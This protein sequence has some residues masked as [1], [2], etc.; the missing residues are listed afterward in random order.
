M[1][2]RQNWDVDVHKFSP[3]RIYNADTFDKHSDPLCRPFDIGKGRKELRHVPKVLIA[4]RWLSKFK[5]PF[6]DH[7]S[8]S[9]GT[10]IG[11]SIVGR[12]YADALNQQC[13]CD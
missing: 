3:L 2:L 1:C 10:V 11:N 13:V 6:E 12:L 5:S 9:D 7:Q 8:V 4:G